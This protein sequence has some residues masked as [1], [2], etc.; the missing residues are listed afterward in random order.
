MKRLT[1]ICIVTL[2]T[3][4]T[5]AICTVSTASCLAIEQCSGGYCTT[6]YS[7]NAPTCTCTDFCENET[8]PEGYNFRTC[9]CKTQLMEPVSCK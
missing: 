9:K 8:F 7:Y 3:T 5:S 1:L 2:Y 6:Q 4:N